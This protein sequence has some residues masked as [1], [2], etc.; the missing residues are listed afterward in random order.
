LR[1]LPKQQDALS[2][3]VSGGEPK[4]RTAP[5]PQIRKWHLLGND[6]A[7]SARIRTPR[8][9]FLPKV[10]LKNTVSSRNPRTSVCTVSEDMRGRSPY[11]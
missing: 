4:G 11:I 6:D 2:R 10:E 9:T 8:C 3:F 5:L 7:R 1:I